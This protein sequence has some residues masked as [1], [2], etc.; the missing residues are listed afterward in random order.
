MDRDLA[1]MNEI[2]G[3]Q[4]DDF[5]HVMAPYLLAP[6]DLD[7]LVDRNS[8]EHLRNLTFLRFAGC[9]MEDMEDPAAFFQGKFEKLFT[10]LHPLNSPIVYGIVSRGGRASLVIGVNLSEGGGIVKSVLQGLLAGMELE[11]CAFDFSASPGRE[12]RG[13]FL[14]AVPALKTEEGKQKFDLS[15]LMRSLNGEAYTI[16]FYAKPVPAQLVREKYTTVLRIR[17][18]CAAVGKRN[19][20]AQQGTNHTRTATRNATR[21]GPVQ[22]ALGQVVRDQR[23]DVRALI[24]SVIDGGNLSSSISDTKTLQSLTTGISYDIQNGMALEMAGFCDRAIE[25]LKFGQGTGLWDVTISYAACGAAC[26]IL[27]ACLCGELAKPAADLLPLRRIPYRLEDG[28]SVYL[29]DDSGENPLLTPVTSAELGMICAPPADIAPDFERKRGKAYP[30]IPVEGRIEIGKVMDGSRP[31]PNMAFAL[32]EE[33]LNRHTFLC[34]ITGS[35]K[36]TTVKGILANCKKPFLVIESA[37]KEYRSLS[38]PDGQPLC[39]YTMGKPEINCLQW[40]PFY[41]QRGV[42]LQTHIDYLKDLFNASFSFY[43]PMTYILEKCLHNIYRKKGWNQTLGYHPYLIDLKS[44]T[45]VF[46]A[47]YMRG[48][49]E[50]KSCGFLF[51]TMQDLK[52]EVKRYIENEMQYEGDVGS[53]IKAAILA[54]L[55]SLCVGSKGYMFNTHSCMD[56][57]ALMEQKAVFELEGLADDDD[58]AFCVGLLIIFINEYRQVYQDEHG[59]AKSGLRHLLVIEEA[60][61]LLK[62]METERTSENM[63]NPKGKAVEHF[64]N[65]L[66]EMRSYGQ[67]VMIAEQIPCKLAPDAIKNSS[68]KIIQ[69]LVSAD[70]QRLAANAVGMKEEEAVYLGSLKK[71]EALCHKEGMSLPVHVAVHPVEK[72]HVSDSDLIA[73]HLDAVFEKI[74]NQM[75]CEKLGAVRGSVSLKLLNTLLA[76]DEGAMEKAVKRSKEQMERELEKADVVLLP[77]KTSELF[78]NIL[79]DWLLSL[80]CGGIYGFGSLPD[81][82]LYEALRQLCIT[83]RAEY[84]KPVKE[85][86]SGLYGRDTGNHCR[87]ILSELLKS[88]YSPAVNLEASI[89]AYFFEAPAALVNEIGMGIKGG[90]DDAAG[91]G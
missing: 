62:N 61:R 38:L 42:S 75:A 10:A 8:A 80:L 83:G 19:V 44:A 76:L 66:A 40:N 46:D 58:K 18:V 24:D 30:L 39:V 73:G 64:T 5:I 74:N 3:A 49:Y 82:E 2:L 78:G 9:T 53:N 65:M 23:L 91:R 31:L 68:N 43:G 28:Q 71:W 13:G 33:D 47:D 54:R 17:D 90:T 57:E 34:G 63:G 69:R 77:G 51:P 52:D 85:K 22:E 25:R 48:R 16:L 87:L 29:P 7:G 6:E 14:C 45:D 79:A 59:N 37:K 12:C 70:D 26:D 86:L 15:A 84:V 20:S 60:H 81:D 27:E 36:T 4:T 32:S 88:R 1:K 21:R 35:G 55:E 72:Q 11:A 50:M 56:M 89:R 67:G 41:V